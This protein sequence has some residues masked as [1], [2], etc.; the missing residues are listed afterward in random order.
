MGDFHRS[1]RVTD[2]REQLLGAILTIVGLEHIGPAI[3]LLYTTNIFGYMFGTPIASVLINLTTPASYVNGA[4]WAG[5][6]IIVG[7]LFAGWV[8]VMKGGWTLAK[9]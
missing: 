5:C 1:W 7:S 4:I 2:K 6:T 3:G 8:R 9:I